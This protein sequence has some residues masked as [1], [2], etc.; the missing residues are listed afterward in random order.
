MSAFQVGPVDAGKTC[1]YCRFPLK[2]GTAAVRCD[3]PGSCGTVHHAEC[4][5]D[6]GGCAVFGCVNAGAA[7]SPGPKTNGPAKPQPPLPPP[8]PGP[9]RP[10]RDRTRW[11]VLAVAVLVA[12]GGVAAAAIVLTHRNS[13]VAIQPPPPPPPVQPPQPPQ[14]PPPTPPAQN[15]NLIAAQKLAQIVEY[16]VQGRDDVQSGRYDAAIANRQATLQRLARLSG[17]TAQL[18][19]AKRTLAR[20]M[21]ASLNADRAYASGDDPSYYNAQATT[22]KRQFVSEWNP[23]A[24]E[25]NLATYSE[26]DI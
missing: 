8:V 16:S 11:A 24:A 26:G 7:P 19:S 6:G 22:L 20:A 9:S 12:V 2:E 10:P 5:A 21:Q 4:W 13:P 1:P 23:I 3:G 17:G 14:P 18:Q 15:P 25:Y